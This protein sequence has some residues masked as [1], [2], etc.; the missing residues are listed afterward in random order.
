M[1]NWRG[2]LESKGEILARE[3][4]ERQGYQILASNYRCP[5]GEIDLIAQDG[6]DLV[7]VEVRLRRTKGFGTVE[8]SLTAAK[9]QRLIRS[10]QYFLQERELK[11]SWR[12]DLVAIEAYGDHRVR[13]VRLLKNA[14]SGE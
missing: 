9:G 3:F 1:R 8:E 6:A 12:I 14:V 7:F 5:W 2:R 13:E 4:L 11:Q 10:A